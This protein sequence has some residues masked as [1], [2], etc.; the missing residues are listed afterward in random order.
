MPGA[1]QRRWPAAPLER[2]VVELLR[3]EEV[4]QQVRDD[5]VACGAMVRGTYGTPEA[6]TRTAHVHCVPPRG[7]LPD[8][9]GTHSTQETGTR[10]PYVQYGGPAR[11]CQHRPAPT[12]P[13]SAVRRRQAGSLAPPRQAQARPPRAQPPPRPGQQRTTRASAWACGLLRPRVAS[14][15]ACRAASFRRN[16]PVWVK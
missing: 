11:T 9:F 8:A 10:S 3:E 7:K 4:Q 5:H 1:R 16:R 2:V 15:G 14:R 13:L 12:R 6:G